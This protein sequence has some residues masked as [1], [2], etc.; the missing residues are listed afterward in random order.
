MQMPSQPVATE[1]LFSG[2]LAHLH[3]VQA[4]RRRGRSHEVQVRLTFMDFLP[5]SKSRPV[6]VSLH[7]SA[8]R[9]CQ[10]PSSTGIKAGLQK[11]SLR[12]D[13]PTVG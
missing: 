10:L 7:G 11:R 2:P 1:N 4:G 13:G 12:A 3:A 9:R 6:E 8:I 5:G